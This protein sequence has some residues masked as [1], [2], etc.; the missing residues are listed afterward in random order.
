MLSTLCSDDR[1]INFT[2]LDL[3]FDDHTGLLDMQRMR[4]DLEDRNYT[5][6]GKNTGMQD[7]SL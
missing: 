2:R 6:R 5:F 7:E 1:K 4:Y 3:A